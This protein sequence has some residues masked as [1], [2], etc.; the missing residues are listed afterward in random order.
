MTQFEAI[1]LKPIKNSFSLYTK[2]N[3]FFIDGVYYSYKQ[4]EERVFAIRE[5]LTICAPDN[6]IVALAIHDDLDTYASIFA[7]WCEGKA[8]V[9]LHPNQP[10]G[11]NKSILEQ[12]GCNYILDSAEKSVFST[13]VP[14]CEVIIT[15]DK[16]C[17]NCEKEFVDCVDSELAYILFT[18][19]STGIP[20]GVCITRGNIAAFMESFWKTGIS[21]T[22]ED[23]CMQC[24]DLSFDVSVQS[25]LVPLT[26]GACVYTVPY[27]Q[28]K[29]LYAASLIQERHITFGA[30]APSMLTYLRPYFDEFDASSLKTCILTA[31]ACPVDLM[32]DWFKC[33]KNTELYDFYG[34]TEATVYCSFY[35]LKRGGK[36]LSLNGIISIGKPLAN[37]SAIIIRDDG[38]LVEG[39]EKGELCVAGSQVTLGY[40]N[41]PEKNATSFFKREGERYYHTGDLCFWDVS[42]NIMYSG[43]IDQQAK[44]QGFR[45]ELGEIEHHAREFYKHEKRV[46]AIAHNNPKGLTE[47][48]LFVESG[49]QNPDSL[50]AYLRSRMPEYMIPT[51]VAYERVFPI[52]NSDKIDR[53]ALRNKLELWKETK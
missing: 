48:A 28:I 36:N 22:S 20:K 47:I 37:V 39:E 8:Y 42:G 14:S 35:K 18:S 49:F 5:A 30:M 33:A 9:P 12:V 46:L 52:N 45:V 3:A 34:P 32:E 53:A 16:S 6:K 23:R 26:R 13:D 24:F 43:R 40:W 38:S 2:Q 21:I 19:G 31:E 10:L 51:R 25:F 7:L 44:I 15:S 50:L 4:F 11:R 1:I 27:G 17:N 29:Y 41:N